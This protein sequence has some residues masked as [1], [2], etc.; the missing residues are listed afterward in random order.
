[1]PSQ[2]FAVPQ[3]WS[4]REM[5]H[6]LSR[7]VWLRKSRD[8]PRERMSKGYTQMSKWMIFLLV[9]TSATARRALG[10]MTFVALDL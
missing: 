2:V 5:L 7:K 9:R 8:E 3:G 6:K 10:M 4:G 1:M